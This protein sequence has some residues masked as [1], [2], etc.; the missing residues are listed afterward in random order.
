[1]RNNINDSIFLDPITKD[2]I[3]EIVA[4]SKCKYSRDIHDLSM[5][6]IKKVIISI[7]HPLVHVFLYFITN[8]VF[9]EQ[10]KTVKILPVQ[11][12]KKAASQISTIVDLYQL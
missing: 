1:M 10:M 12:L 11:Y 2:E 9:P 5:V 8:G 3:V 4:Q 6:T 7:S